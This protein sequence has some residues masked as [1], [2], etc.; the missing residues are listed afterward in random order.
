MSALE[1][2]QYLEF[3]REG[4]VWV[5][6]PATG[7]LGP[8]HLYPLQE[9]FGREVWDVLD[10]QTRVRRFRRA[11]FSVQKKFGKT[12]GPGATSGLYHLLFDPFERDR[13]IYSIAGDYDQA[14]LVLKAAKKMIRFSPTL[15]SLFRYGEKGGQ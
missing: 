9:T 13:E 14:L 1:E 5:P 6:D 12:S 4:Y 7:K 10:P 2:I 3:I 15:R 11:V 8:M